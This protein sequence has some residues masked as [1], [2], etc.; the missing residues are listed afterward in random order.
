[1]TE[2]YKHLS[3]YLFNPTIGRVVQQYKY[4]PLF[5]YTL[6]TVQFVRTYLIAR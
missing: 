3:I 5:I 2:F 1:M 4:I 6:F